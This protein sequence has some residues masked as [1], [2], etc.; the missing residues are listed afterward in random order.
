MIRKTCI[1]IFAILFLN[2]S[3]DEPP[4]E[5]PL[6]SENYILD[7]RLKINGD[8]V[9]GTINDADNTI[10]F[11]LE[12]A[13]LDNLAPEI[14]YSVK[15]KISPSISAPQDF[16][17]E[18]TYTVTA[19]NGDSRTYKVTVNNK[20]ITG[21]NEILSFS[22]PID[23]EV[24]DGVISETT[25]IIKFE[26]AGANIDNLK[27]TVQIS[28]NASISPA[29]DVSQDFTNEVSYTIIAGN[30]TATIYRVQ[31]DNRPLSIEKNVI[32]LS[33]SDGTI[34]SEA[35][36]DED[37]GIISFDFGNLDRTNL[38]PTIT[39]PEYAT[40]SP[41]L[42]VAQDFT[43]PVTYTVTAEDGSTKT[44][45]VIA[46]LPEVE[47]IGG[48]SFPARFFVGADLLITGKFL[49]MSVPGSQIHLYDGVNKYPI[50]VESTSS[51]QVS[52]TQLF[53][54][55]NIFATIPESTPTNANYKISYKANGLEIISEL[56]A[57]IK[58]ENAPLPLAVD[59]AEYRY[60]D[61]LIMTGE[62]LTAYIAIPSQ[63]GS[64]YLMD[65][66]GSDISAN[67]TGTEMQVVLD[68]R[69]VFPSYFGDGPRET[70]IIVLDE[71]RRRGRRI[72]V[73]F[74]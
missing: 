34:T 25:K 16:S 20:V 31:V 44:Y 72:L 1:L 42:D 73:N 9:S 27:P 22:L 23:G 12:G 65:P 5:L 13:A 41:A 52:S 10:N 51:Y 74:Y 30:G 7:F 55:Y 33:L 15:S 14:T 28:E 61:Q 48:R 8:F 24:V 68:I 26:L 50:I 36:I 66:R 29:P 70:T 11:N 43:D 46:N 49:D 37:S 63:N 54:I 35:V 2:C 32:S 19:E 53:T 69:Q 3:K 47:N 57:D 21:E 71:E 45:R 40:V 60:D 6:S 62:N 38:T 18:T 56:T 4:V 59:K 39:L 67:P 64:I 17:T 58:K